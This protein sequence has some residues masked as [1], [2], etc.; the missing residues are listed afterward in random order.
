MRELPTINEPVSMLDLA[1]EE[2]E[3][4]SREVRELAAERTSLPPTPH[5]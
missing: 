4:M 1:P 5:R 2:I 3:D